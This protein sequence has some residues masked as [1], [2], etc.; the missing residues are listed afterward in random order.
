MVRDTPRPRFVKE[1]EIKKLMGVSGWALRS[2]ADSGKIKSIRTPGGQRL[3]EV[4]DLGDDPPAVS[5]LRP[6]RGAVYAR[7]SSHKQQDDL[8]RQIAFLSAK[9]PDHVV[10]SDIA[11]GINWKRKGLRTL[12][13]LADAGD[14]GEVVVAARDRLCRFAFEFVEHVLGTRGVKVTVLD[15]S[16]DTTEEQELADDLLGIVQVFC[17]RKNG[18]RR[19]SAADKKDQA[20]PQP[21]AEEEA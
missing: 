6:K 1:R 13:E 12:L 3:Y 18:R 7:V 10:V 11:S 4:P 2:W 5:P 20:E 21:P 9:Y 8:H 14:I 19:Y 15:S 16:A 17:C